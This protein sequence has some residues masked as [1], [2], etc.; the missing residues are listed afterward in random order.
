MFLSHIQMA[1]DVVYHIQLQSS[2]IEHLLAPILKC[3]CSVLHFVVENIEGRD[4][5]D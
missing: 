5:S 2:I 1:N 3:H 4:A